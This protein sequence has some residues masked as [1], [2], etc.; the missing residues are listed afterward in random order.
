MRTRFH[1][2]EK[3][4]GTRRAK[5]K[6]PSQGVTSDN[7]RLQP[8][9]KEKLWRRNYTLELIQTSVYGAKDSVLLLPVCRQTKPNQTKPNQNKT[10]QNKTK[11]NKTKQNKTKL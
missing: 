9:S 5:G 6:K 4:G 11:Q 8:D 3:T 2:N 10:K 1:E 7:I